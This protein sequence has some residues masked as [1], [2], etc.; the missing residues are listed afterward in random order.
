MDWVGCQ[1]VFKQHQDQV[2][3]SRNPVLT[4]TSLS[5]S[6][7]VPVSLALSTPLAALAFALSL[8]SAALDFGF[9][10]GGFEFPFTWPLGN[11]PLPLGTV[12]AAGAGMVFDVQQMVSGDIENQE[13]DEEWTNRRYFECGGRNQ[14]SGCIL[15]PISTSSH[16][17]LFHIRINTHRSFCRSATTRTES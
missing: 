11:A 9:P 17:S 14:I 1:F 3:M 7:S 13:T 4:S 8:L 15:P 10:P 5:L 12:V 2:D 6:L 16:P